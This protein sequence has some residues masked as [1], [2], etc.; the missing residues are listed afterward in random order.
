MSTTVYSQ[1]WLDTI[2]YPF[3]NKYLQLTEGNMHYVDEG[4]GETILFVHGTPTWSFLYRN[5]IKEL[6]KDH[7]CIAIDHIGFGLSE[8]TTSQEKTPEW[9]A[10]NLS[11]FIQKLD[12]SNITLVVHDFGG[13]I[14]LGAGIAN[15]DRIKKVV[16]LNS[17]L[18]ATDQDKEALKADKT[19]NSW[20]GKFLYLNMNFSPKVLLKKGFS[21]KKNLPKKVHQQ[22]IKPFPNKESRIPLLD[23]AKSLVGS[24]EWYQEQWNKLHKLDDKDWL[25]LWGTKDSF[26]TPK[27][28][29]KW[30]DRLP[31]AKLIAFDCGHF[32]QEERADESVRAIHDFIK[33]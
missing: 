26:I 28:L 24:S 3:E 31:D 23:L 27:Y 21:D 9:H 2:S 29:K 30:Q 25:I 12:L 22:Y 5:F 33:E 10:R 20:M 1:S 14:G 17:W 19:I 15:S 16:L 6:S 4:K 18:W 13:P 32:I 7:R 11:E 8:K